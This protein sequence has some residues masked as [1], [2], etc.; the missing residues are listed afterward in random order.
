MIGQLGIILRVIEKILTGLGSL[1][2]LIFALVVVKQVTS[3]SKEVHDK[4]NGLLIAFSYLHLIFSLA[5]LVL[6][7]I[8]L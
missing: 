5:L 4:F 6:A 3:M 1:V 7:L 2:Y 8:L